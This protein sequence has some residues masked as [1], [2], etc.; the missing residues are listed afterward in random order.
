MIGVN[1]DE[2][3]V[4]APFFETDDL[5]TGIQDIAKSLIYVNAEAILSSG[6][7]PLGNGPVP[8]NQTLDVFNTT[9]RIYTDFTFRCVSQ[10]IAFDG[11]VSGSFPTVWFFEFNRTYQDPSYDYY[12]VCQPP[13]TEQHPY[14]DPSMEYFKCHGGDLFFTFGTVDRSEL[15]FRDENDKPYQQLVT[16]YWTSFGRSYDPNPDPGFLRARGYW[17]TLEQISVAGHWPQVGE[18]NPQL[19]QLQWNPLV[20][21][22]VDEPQ[23]TVIGEPVNSLLG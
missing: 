14:G 17:S 8:A 5:E 22:F 12:D 7:F 6:A 3:G 4:L 19:M 20:R 13:K 18:Q 2:G 23:C 11:A 1:R 21:P 15:P 16:D 9:T 10:A